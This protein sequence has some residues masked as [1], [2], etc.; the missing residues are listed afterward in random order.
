MKLPRGVSRLSELISP[1]LIFIYY[2]YYVPFPQILLEEMILVMGHKGVLNS[3]KATCRNI[4]RS[5]NY[6]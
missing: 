2:Q 5:K 4:H 3:V 6:L 1:N